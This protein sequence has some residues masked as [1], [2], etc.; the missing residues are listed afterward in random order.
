[1]S[2][3]LVLIAAILLFRAFLPRKSG[4]SPTAIS[5]YMNSLDDLMS[6]EQV[7]LATDEIRPHQSPMA[8]RLPPPAKRGAESPSL[9]I[10]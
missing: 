1:M 5:P 8:D 9:S 3:V 4:R 6:A 10:R 7:S 2:R